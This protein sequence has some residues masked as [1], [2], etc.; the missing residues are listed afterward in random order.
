[1]S[2]RP[3]DLA[4][5]GADEGREEA[6]LDAVGKDLHVDFAVTGAVELS[7]ED[8]LPAAEEESAFFNKDKLRSTGEHGL[9]VGVRVAFGVA[10]KAGGRHETVEGAFRV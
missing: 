10:I 2:F 8:T 4:G 9:D 5:V 1:M 3:D 7:K 6:A